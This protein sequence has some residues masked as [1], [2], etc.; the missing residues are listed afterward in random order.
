VAFDIRSVWKVAMN[1]GKLAMNLGQLA[2]RLNN[3][4]KSH[5]ID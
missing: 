2:M 1:L 4:C 3:Y 5:C